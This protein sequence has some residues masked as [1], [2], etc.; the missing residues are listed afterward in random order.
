MLIF[1]DESGDPGWK[2]DAGSSKYFIVALVG[3]E[4]RD[5]ALAVDDR[6]S[7]LRKEHGFPAEFEFHFTKIKP[8]YR[9][10]FL[11]AVAPYNFFYFG[12]VIEKAMLTGGEFQVKQSFYKAACG[13]IFEYAKLRVSNALILIDER[14]S[15]NL[16]RELKSYLVRHLKNE[17][18]KC[19]IKTVRTQNSRQNNLLQLADMVVGAV[20][21]FHSDKKD[22]REYRRL[23]AHRELYVR[24]WPK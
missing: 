11:K 20:A 13:L 6:I 14:G 17:P 10:M 12:I 8:V 2:I 9:R 19:F 15:K 5:E 7:Q 21:R 16:G 3:F 4:D 24:F 22:S 18:G 23:I 1:I